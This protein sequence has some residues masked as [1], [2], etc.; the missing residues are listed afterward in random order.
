MALIGPDDAGRRARIRRTTALL[1]AVAAVVY[2]GAIY[3]QYRRSR[4]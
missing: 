4:G 2:A 1:L 3:L